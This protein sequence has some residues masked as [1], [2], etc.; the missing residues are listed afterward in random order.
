MPYLTDCGIGFTT[1]C[2]DLSANLWKIGPPT[3]CLTMFF[4][5]ILALGWPNGLL[6]LLDDQMF[7]AFP[8]AVSD[9]IEEGLDE[10]PLDKVMDARTV[11]HRIP[12]Q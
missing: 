2:E 3:V 1:N 5:G 12:L 8:A 6:T 10:D 4:H 11:L 7:A 9:E